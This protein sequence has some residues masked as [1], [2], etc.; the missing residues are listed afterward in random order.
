MISRER[1]KQPHQQREIRDN[2]YFYTLAAPAGML[3][4]FATR[5]GRGA[6]GT[7]ATSKR[8]IAKTLLIGGYYHTN[9]VEIPKSVSSFITLG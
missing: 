6:F 3:S 8:V 7:V 5:K 1:L 9:F 2:I 4:D